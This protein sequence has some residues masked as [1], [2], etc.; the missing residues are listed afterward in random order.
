MVDEVR[1]VF[2]AGRLRHP[3]WRSIRCRGVGG[4]GGGCG[5]HASSIAHGAD[6]RRYFGRRG[7]NAQ[8]I[9]AAIATVTTTVERRR[10]DGIFTQF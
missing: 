2:V 9:N 7:W 3:E 8:F 5:S 6:G 4:G 1:M 10:N